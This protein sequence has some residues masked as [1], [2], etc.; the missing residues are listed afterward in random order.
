MGDVSQEITRIPVISKVS[1]TTNL[2]N[3]TGSLTLFTIAGN[4]E[5]VKLYGI[6]TTVLSAN[7]TAA[8]FRLN[9]GTNV[10]VLTLATGTTM[11]AAAVGSIIAATAL[12]ATAVT[13]ANGSQARVTQAAAANQI[14][15]Q[16]QILTAKNGATTTLEY[17]YTTTDIPSSGAIQFFM[18]WQ[19]LS[20]DASVS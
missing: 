12:A 9:D 3:T 14:P 10:P 16:G 17:R 4:I 1:K 5:L 18:W 11:S 19:P 6:V 8:H 7:H 15:F 20:D 13:L 2:S